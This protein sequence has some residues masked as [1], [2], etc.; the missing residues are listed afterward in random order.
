M[1][2]EVNWFWHLTPHRPRDE[3]KLIS[4]GLLPRRQTTTSLLFPSSQLPAW[5]SNRVDDFASWPTTQNLAKFISSWFDAPTRPTSV[6]ATQ[7]VRTRGRGGGWSEA[8]SCPSAGCITGWAPEAPGRVLRGRSPPQ[9]RSRRA[10][11]ATCHR[12]AHAFPAAAPPAG[13]RMR[14]RRRRRAGGARGG[15]GCRCRRRC[16]R[17]VPGG[18]WRRGWGRASWG[19]ACPPRSVWRGAMNSRKGNRAVCRAAGR[20]RRGG[21]ARQ[22]PLTPAAGC[23]LLPGSAGPAGPQAAAQAVRGG[24]QEG[25]APATPQKVSM[26]TPDPPGR[27]PPSPPGRLRCLPFPHAAP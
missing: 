17:P 15:G 8:K 4:P 26:G 1:C 11:A 27:S 6:P 16:C 24:R 18:D 19:A 13:P 14:S 12:P 7:Q 21:A 23:S 3:L 10:R 2:H 20:E 9:V 22:P 5:R 25:Q